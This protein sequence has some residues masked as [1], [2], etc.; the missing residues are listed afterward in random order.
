MLAFPNNTVD[1]PVKQIKLVAYTAAFL[2]FNQKLRWLATLEMLQSFLGLLYVL[3]KILLR[4]VRHFFL[5][6]LLYAVLYFAELLGDL[7]T[8]IA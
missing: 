1:R 4:M 5:Y 2:M 8:H 3:E 7:L 6:N